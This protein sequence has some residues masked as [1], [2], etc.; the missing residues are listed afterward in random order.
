MSQSRFSEILQSD[1]AS[2]SFLLTGLFLRDQWSSR[3]A[4]TLPMGSNAHSP[5]GRG[6][7]PS[8]RRV[9]VADHPANGNIPDPRNSAH[10]HL[11]RYT[12]AA[13]VVDGFRIMVCMAISTSCQQFIYIRRLLCSRRPA[14]VSGMMD[15]YGQ[16]K[17][18]Q[19]HRR[20]F[21]QSKPGFC[22]A[23]TCLAVDD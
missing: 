18:N 3:T 16:A 13:R 20:L 8:R 1:V 7:G 23:I 15:I 11:T 6:I 14:Q 17:R 2:Q 21:Y 12:C 22:N 4:V 10:L 19:R 9:W 5:R